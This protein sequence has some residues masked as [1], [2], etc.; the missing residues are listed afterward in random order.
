MKPCKSCPFRR[1]ARHGLWSPAHYLLIA[2]LGSADTPPSPV[3]TM[4][5]HQF[6]GKSNKA[7]EPE[8]PPMF[9]T[10]RDLCGGWI[11]AARDSIAVRIAVMV[12][13]EIDD[14]YD[15]YDV[16]SPEEMAR[17]NG[18]DLDNPE[19]PPLRWSHESGE[20]YF[21]WLSRHRT[22][23]EKIQKNQEYARRFVL[24]GSPLDNPPT[25]EEIDAIFG[26]GRHSYVKTNDPL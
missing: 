11:R 8:I 12:R 14:V 10:G 15:G 1:D 26:E 3:P 9:S 4:G 5:C 18:I 7:F 24:P 17:V 13:G 6:N 21:D 25:S 16:M 23:R 22:L 2:Y 20:S 19:I